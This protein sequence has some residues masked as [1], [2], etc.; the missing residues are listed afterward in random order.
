MTGNLKGKELQLYNS[1]QQ[2]IPYTNLD[3]LNS[4]FGFVDPSIHPARQDKVHTAQL[5]YLIALGS[6]SLRRIRI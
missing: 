5:D 3:P 2:L 1:I 6:K 4:Y